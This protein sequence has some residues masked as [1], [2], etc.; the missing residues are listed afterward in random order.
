MSF[1]DKVFS[2]NWKAIIGFATAVGSQLLARAFINGEA[3]FPTDARGW[4]A[5][6]G[7]SLLAGGLI[8]AKGNQYT[9]DQLQKKLDKAAAKAPTNES[10]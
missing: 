10:P 1:I 4:A 3:V 6:V 8:W 9:I 7:G 5:L 2:A